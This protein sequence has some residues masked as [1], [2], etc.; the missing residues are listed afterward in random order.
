MTPELSIRDDSSYLLGPLQLSEAPPV[1]ELSITDDSS[2]RKP[3][4]P[5]Y[6]LGPVELSEAPVH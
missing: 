3:P 2:Y 1:S 5:S 4:M 6:L